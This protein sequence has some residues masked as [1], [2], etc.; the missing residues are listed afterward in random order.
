MAT[1]TAT[2]ST[3]LPDETPGYDPYQQQY[4]HPRMQNAMTQNPREQRNERDHHE[5]HTSDGSSAGDPK[6]GQNKKDTS[7]P[8]EKDQLSKYINNNKTM[9]YGLLFVVAL[10]IIAVGYQ[11]LHQRKLHAEIVKHQQSQPTESGNDPPQAGPAGNQPSGPKPAAPPKQQPS[12]QPN[13]QS[14]QRRCP[15]DR[16]AER[17]DRILKQSQ[18]KTAAVSSNGAPVA[19]GQSAMSS[20]R[21]G[22][23]DEDDRRRLATIVEES[24]TMS[25]ND[26][27]YE[28]TRAIIAE[29]LRRDAENDA[30]DEPLGTGSVDVIDADTIARRE[31]RKAEMDNSHLEERDEAI[32]EP[33]CAVVDDDDIPADAQPIT[34][35]SVAEKIVSLCSQILSHGQRA[36]QECQRECKPGKTKCERHLQLAAKKSGGGQ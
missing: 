29:Q 9:V 5:P 36:G 22:C 1:K 31:L 11:A 14:D 13:R 21:Q 2:Y 27:V 20:R 6:G 34:V 7:A 18:Q 28:R 3:I 26:P 16:N 24:E 4:S 17:N 19:R 30:G 8:A 35:S 32:V 15:I 12:D 25:G 33:A 10:L 23:S